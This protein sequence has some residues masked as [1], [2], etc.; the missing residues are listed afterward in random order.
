M[1]LATWIEGWAN[2]VGIELNVDPEEQDPDPALDDNHQEEP[3]PRDKAT[4]LLD[5]MDC[6]MDVTSQEAK[7][8]ADLELLHHEGLITQAE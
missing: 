6:V 8:L 4:V 3:T 5:P 1:L 2:S 7:A